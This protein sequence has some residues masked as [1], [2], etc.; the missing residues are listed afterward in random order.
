MGQNTR[1]CGA[2]TFSVVYLLV[3]S[4]TGGVV[5]L[6]PGICMWWYMVIHTSALVGTDKVGVKGTT[7]N[8]SPVRG[9]P[10]VSLPLLSFPMIPLIYPCLYVYSP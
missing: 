1:G 4:E 9:Y 2:L 5:D 10:S 6:P 3:S 8:P 7:K